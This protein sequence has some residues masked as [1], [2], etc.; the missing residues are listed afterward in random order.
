MQQ[1]IDLLVL[2]ELNTKNMNPCGVL[3]N[4]LVS[5][6]VE[7]ILKNDTCIKYR[8]LLYIFYDSLQRYQ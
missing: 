3:A 8:L 7:N 1:Y 5:Y 2:I 6:T 4:M